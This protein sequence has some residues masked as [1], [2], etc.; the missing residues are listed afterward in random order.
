MIDLTIH[1]DGQMNGTKETFSIKIGD[2][3]IW[4]KEYNNMESASPALKDL[5]DVLTNLIDQATVIT[6]DLAN[7]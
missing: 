2:L 1:Y 5:H 7:E 3:V 4:E 6:T